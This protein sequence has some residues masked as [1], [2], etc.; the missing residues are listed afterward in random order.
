M[1]SNYTPKSDLLNGRVILVTGASQGI[2]AAVAETYAAYGATVILLARTVKKL[3][4]LYDKIEQAGYP[5]PAIYPMNLANATPRDFEELAQ[6]INQ[7]FGRLDGLLHNAAMLG[8]LTPIEHYDIE[9]WYHIMQVNLH[10]AFL[11][12]Q[13]T[14][15]LLKR[16]QSASVIFTTAPTGLNGKAYWGAYGV[17][18]FALQGLM[19][20]L[21]DEL[22]VNT[23]VR[24]NSINPVQARTQLR[25]NIYPAENPN[26]SP[27][28][29]EILSP[30]LY[31]MG[32]DSLGV[33]GKT[34]E[35]FP[36]K[37]PLA[38]A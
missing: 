18:K 23:A 36:Q 17:S 3:E 2:G 27:A 38:F 26:L 24:V 37:A 4:A 31:L 33:T 28:P 8:G 7:H 13:F 15:P 30:Y 22:E 34:I 29:E 21:A 16:A 32:T 11:L 5:K 14:L 19:Q 9:Q 1:L 12:T 6:N 20:T 35:A 25:R 10:S